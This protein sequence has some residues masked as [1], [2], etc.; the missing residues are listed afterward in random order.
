MKVYYWVVGIAYSLYP[1]YTLGHLFQIVVWN[2]APIFDEGNAWGPFLYWLLLM[3][4]AAGL[5]IVM[6]VFAWVKK[7]NPVKPLGFLGL[8]VLLHWG[9]MYY[10]DSLW[11]VYANSKFTKECPLAVELNLAQVNHDDVEYVYMLKGFTSTCGDTYLLDLSA[12]DGRE[13]LW[14]IEV[15]WMDGIWQKDNTYIKSEHLVVTG[16]TDDMVIESKGPRSLEGRPLRLKIQ[17]RT[18]G[19]IYRHKVEKEFVDSLRAR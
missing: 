5:V 12:D 13:R 3:L 18:D 17:N 16:G 14:A 15:K 19:S 2:R 11:S 9:A 10:S 7:I 4:V 8:F 1:I 6:L